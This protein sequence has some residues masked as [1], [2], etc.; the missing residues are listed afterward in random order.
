MANNVIN[1]RKLSGGC[2]DNKRQDGDFY[3][4]PDWV[5]DALLDNCGN[6]YRFSGN[7]WECACGDGRLAKRIMDKCPLAEVYSSDLF[8]RGYGDCDIDFLTA[9]PDR[10]FDWIITNPPFELA[11]DFMKKA[12]RIVKRGYAF[13]LPIRYLTGKKRAEFYRVNQPSKIIVIPQKVDFMGNGNPI[14]EFAWFI[15]DKYCNKG[16]T[17]LYWHHP[18]TECTQSD[19]FAA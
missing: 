19:L 16:E 17:K 1:K 2:G 9:V 4:T 14:M 15:W 5:S 6:D 11:F 10:Q 7:I 12:E 13:L 3:P 18:R 8:N